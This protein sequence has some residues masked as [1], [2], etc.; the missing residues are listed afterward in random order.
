ME[1]EALV[2]RI[3]AEVMEQLKAMGLQKRPSGRRALVLSPE[4][5]G[6]GAVTQELEALGIPW[7]II[8]GWDSS[9]LDPSEED[10]LVVP[11]LP[12]SS[13]AYIAMGIEGDCL[14]KSVISRLFHGK[15]ILM[16]E[17]GMAHRRF[18]K[19]S[20][21]AFYQMYQEYEGKLKQF[22]IKVGKLQDLQCQSTPQPVAKGICEMEKLPTEVPHIQTRIITEQVLNS[23]ELVEH[24]KISIS[25][26]AIL[27]PLAKDYIRAKKIEV[28]RG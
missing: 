16:L 19:T 8:K 1:M 9:L 23:L 26:K 14:A 6:Y 11:E 13:L 3:T 15:E 10:I 28:I 25:P 7:Q 24:Q 2:Q 4:G 22:G 12:V 21:V 27:T 17:D 20:G 18:E 5:S